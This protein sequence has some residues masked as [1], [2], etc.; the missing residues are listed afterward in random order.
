MILSVL[1]SLSACSLWPGY[2]NDKR[3]NAR[4]LPGEEAQAQP[5]DPNL[6]RPDVG[7]KQIKS[8][9]YEVGGYAGIIVFDR[10]HTSGLYGV[11]AAYHKSENFFVEGNY[12]FASTVGYNQA[13]NLLGGS[14]GADIKY[15]SF[16]FSAGYNLIPGDLYVSRG[17]TVPFVIYGIGGFGFAKFEDDSHTSYS[18]GAGLKMMP[19]DWLAIRFELRDQAWSAYGIDHN[20]EFTF[21]LAGYF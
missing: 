21:G 6:E 11:R 17:Y 3:D 14:D 5:V 12:A 8:Q 19:T 9:D 4:P 10:N 1:A 16:G 13:R 2:E 7:I 15:K 18:L 20:A